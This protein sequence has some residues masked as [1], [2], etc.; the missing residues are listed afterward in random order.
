VA[1]HRRGVEDDAVHA[2]AHAHV[3]AA[4][5][6]VDVRHAPAYGVGDHGVHELHDRRLVGRLAQ[7]DHLGLV[8]VLLDLVDGALERAQLVDQRVDVLGRGDSA[9]HVVPGGHRDVVEG[10]QVGR[11]GGGHE[12]R[13]L[14]E[15]GDRDRAVAARLCAVDHRGRALVDVEDVQVHVVERVALG[16]RLGELRRV[17]DARVDQ[18]LAQR[19]AVPAAPLDDPLHHFALGEAELDDHVSDP[20]LDAGVLG[21]RDQ[22]RNGEGPG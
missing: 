5:L 7:L 16:E 8:V 10:E 4:R 9:A 20:A 21:G 19:D 18:R 12:Q 13:L 22:P 1:R 6:E 11:V 14:G 2:E 3:V 17:D 15:E